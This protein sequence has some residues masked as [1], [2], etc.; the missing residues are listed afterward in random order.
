[1]RKGTTYSRLPKKFALNYKYLRII[2]YNARI[3]LIFKKKYTKFERYKKWLSRKNIK[4]DFGHKI[5]PKW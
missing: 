1:M 5:F 2:C 3:F 4:W